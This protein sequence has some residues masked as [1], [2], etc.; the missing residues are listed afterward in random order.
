MNRDLEKLY[1]KTHELYELVSRSTVDVDWN[2]CERA[3]VGMVLAALREFMIVLIDKIG[4]RE[5]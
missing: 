2:R 5:T 4:G 3:V 1:S